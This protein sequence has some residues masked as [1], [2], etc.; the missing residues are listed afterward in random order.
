MGGD[1]KRKSTHHLRSSLPEDWRWQEGE[2]AMVRDLVLDVVGVDTALI[3]GIVGK[4][5]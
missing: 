1:E 5:D 4:Y 3:E 2:G